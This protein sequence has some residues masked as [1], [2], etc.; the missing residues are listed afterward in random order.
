MVTVILCSAIHDGRKVAPVRIDE[1]FKEA[2]VVVQAHV[3][4][5][6]KVHG[7]RVA[8]AR[9]GKTYKG[10]IKTASVS[11]VADPTWT[12]DSSQ[13]TVGENILLYLSN[14]SDREFTKGG[15]A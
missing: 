2:V 5:V 4:S 6:T 10:D 14:P 1:L 11:F 12:C 3:D 15:A 9:V 13:A 8:N 7:V